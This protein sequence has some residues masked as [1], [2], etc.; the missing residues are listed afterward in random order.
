MARFNLLA[1]GK[2]SES[3]WHRQDWYLNAAAF[4][5]SVIGLLLVWAASRPRLSASGGDPNAYLYRH[6]AN[7]MIGIFLGYVISRSKYTMLRAFAPVLYLIGSLGLVVVLLIGTEINGVKA[8]IQLPQG[9]TLQPSEFAKIALVLGMAL[10]LAETRQR[11]FEPENR[12]VIISLAL[13]AFPLGLIMLQPDLGTAIVIS[14]IVLGVLGVGGVSFRW[15]IGLVTTGVFVIIAVIGFGFLDE[16]QINR[17]I[18][19]L[20]PSIDPLVTGYNIIQVKLAI[21]SGGFGGTGLFNGPLT[22]GGFVPEQQTDFIYSVAGEEFGFVGSG[23]IIFLL[24]FITWRAL[25]IARESSDLFGRIAAS[26]VAIWLGFQTFENI[27]MNLGIMP[28]TGVPLPFVS[29]GGTATFAVWM[30]IGLLQNIK[31]R[32]TE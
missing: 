21:G 20:D 22:N 29:Y 17:L 24:G 23:I 12:E 5:L 8:W 1:R 32:L 31:S 11:G 4:S 7:I 3:W 25:R 16:Y 9:F 6:A 18:V 19:F 27:G 10:I 28:I 26:G 13:A 15:M 30:A 2:D 14:F